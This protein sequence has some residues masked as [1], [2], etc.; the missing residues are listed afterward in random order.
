MRFSSA[1]LCGLCSLAV[2]AVKTSSGGRACGATDGYFVAGRCGTS[3]TRPTPITRP[4]ARCSI[5]VDLATA[6][7]VF[8]LAR[9]VARRICWAVG[10]GH[11]VVPVHVQHAVGRAGRTSRHPDDLRRRRRRVPLSQERRRDLAAGP[12][13]GGRRSAWGLR[14]GSRCTAASSRSSCWSTCFGARLR[15][16]WRP[17][18][19]FAA[20]AVFFF[21]VADGS[22]LFDPLMYVK[23]R[24]ATYHDDYLALHPLGRSVPRHPAVDRMGDRAARARG[25]RGRRFAERPAPQAVEERGGDRARLAGHLLRDA[26]AARLLDAAGRA[27]VLRAGGRGLLARLS[28]RAPPHGGAWRG[29]LAV[30]VGQTAALALADRAHGLERAARVGRRRRCSRASGSTSWATPILR[31]P[32]NT[33]TMRIYKTA[34][35]REIGVG[36]GQR[37]AV[38][39]AASEEL[40]RARARCG[41]ST[42][43]GYRND[44]GYTLFHYRDLP[45]E[46]FGDLVALDRMDYLI[47][48]RRAFRSPTCRA[49]PACWRRTSGSWASGEA[50]AATAAAWCTASTGGSLR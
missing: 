5:G 15:A 27:A 2:F 14:P 11:G 46:K 43:S 4:T 28:R 37:H 33:A 38:R 7:L 3:T 48:Q 35:E 44:A 10:L 40:G 19:A 9:R 26:P 8:K 31:L 50:K 45:P 24:W 41:C 32:K 34:Y 22:L 23:A 39:G 29:I 1:W 17:A 18:A 21:L 13:S 30:M 36:P 12:R 20:T 42:C 49:S 6:L 47:V 16:G 25:R